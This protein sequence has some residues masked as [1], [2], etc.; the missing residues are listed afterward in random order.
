VR[1]PLVVLLC[2]TVSERL[3]QAVAAIIDVLGDNGE[4][5]MEDFRIAARK[6]NYDA[7]QAVDWL[8]YHTDG[9]KRRISHSI[10]T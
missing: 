5:Y 4:F 7:D 2:L 9:K 10:V 6:F 3:D 1:E 8:L